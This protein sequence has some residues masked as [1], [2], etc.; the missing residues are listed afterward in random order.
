MERNQ[1]MANGL[2]NLRGHSFWGTSVRSMVPKRWLGGKKEKVTPACL[3]FFFH[4]PLNPCIRNRAAASA[5]SVASWDFPSPPSSFSPHLK[6]RGWRVSSSLPTTTPVSRR[7]SAFR[8]SSIGPKT[9]KNKQNV[10]RF[11][12]AVHDLLPAHLLRNNWGDQ[13]WK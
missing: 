13:A 3:R 10:G 6:V 1:W 11:S 4:S 5:V 12:S 8:A 7:E 2:M 9:I